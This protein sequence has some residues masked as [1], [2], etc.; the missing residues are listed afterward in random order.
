MTNS[1]R[2]A[3]TN[4]LE[5]TASEHDGL[6]ELAWEDFGIND[7]HARSLVELGFIAAKA[8]HA[9]EDSFSRDEV[10][11][12]LRAAADHGAAEAE[13]KRDWPVSIDGLIEFYRKL[14]EPLLT[15]TP[16]I[17]DKKEL[18]ELVD[19]LAKQFCDPECRDCD[20]GIYDEGDEWTV[21]PVCVLRP[22]PQGPISEAELDAALDAYDEALNSDDHWRGENV[23]RAVLT[24]ARQADKP[25]GP[26]R[27]PR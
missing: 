12:L 14:E 22:S 19:R 16:R 1:K 26:T 20:S 5:L 15:I 21:C 7:N 13:G 9:A 6:R 27:R 11:E 18:R 8:Y 4:A 2:H 17:N 3:T 23:V 24:A 10:E 25:F